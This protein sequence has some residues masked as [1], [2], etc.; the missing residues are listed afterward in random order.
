MEYLGMLMQ[1]GPLGLV[2]W[3]WIIVLALAV[4]IVVGIFKKAFKLVKLVILLGIIFMALSYFGIIQY[5][6]KLCEETKAV[7]W[8]YLYSLCFG[9]VLCVL[10]MFFIPYI[11]IRTTTLV[12]ALFYVIVCVRELQPVLKT[13]P[14]RQYERVDSSRNNLTK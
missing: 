6:L 10:V 11:G 1:T 8:E 3:Q 9:F 7:V 5:M 2:V 14:Y 4:L 12:V 13:D